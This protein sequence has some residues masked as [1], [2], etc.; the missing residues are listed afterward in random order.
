MAGLRR[1]YYET[2]YG[3]TA[4]YRGGKYAHDL[5]SDERIPVCMLYKFI[6]PL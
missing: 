1:G 2:E 4:V 3:N 6:R 5:D